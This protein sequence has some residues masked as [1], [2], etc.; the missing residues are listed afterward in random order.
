MQKAAQENLILHQMDVKTAYLHA[1]ID[2]EISWKTKKQPTVALSTC[3]A[4]YMALAATLQECVYLVQ[5]LEGIDGHQ[6]PTP[7]VYE[8]N[9]GTLALAKNPVYRQR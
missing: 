7:K 4:E 5:L 1:P 6:Y 3:E 9:Q 2:C 8:D